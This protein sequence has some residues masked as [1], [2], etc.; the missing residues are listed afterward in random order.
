MFGRL[1]R[2][3]PALPETLHLAG[4]EVPVVLVRS[5]R[6]RRILLRADAVSGSIR[7]TL[8]PQVSVGRGAAF[9]SEYTG[10]LE[11][12]VA[13]WPRPLP[14]MPGAAI[15][16][17]GGTLRIELAPARR[18]IRDG[19]RLIVGGTADTLP[20]RVTRW[21]KATALA[22]LTA[23][24]LALAARL[25]LPAPGVRVGDPAGRWGSCSST[26][27]IAYSWRL[28]FAPPAVRA[29]VVAHEVA[30]L[31]HPNHGAAFWALARDLGGDPAPHR[32]W[33]ARHG[34]GLH[35]IGRAT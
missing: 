10:W 14:F 24:T 32:R 35:W 22:D 12:H 31:V 26:R 20:G 19:D 33:L 15:P 21:L 30:H 1:R 7:L 13:T 9:L 25:D 34:A 18:T 4:R 29:S 2:G 5:A 11:A 3:A 16:F 23:A 17:D 27:R 8:P 28:I 6:A